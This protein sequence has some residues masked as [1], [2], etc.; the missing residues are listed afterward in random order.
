[1]PPSFGKSNNC[2]IE[3]YHKKNPLSIDIY[4]KS[5]ICNVKSKEVY[6]EEP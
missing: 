6:V 2:Y 5:K 4:V 3:S 1:M